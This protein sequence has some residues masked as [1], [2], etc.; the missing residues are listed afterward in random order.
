MY[1]QT[2]VIN[3]GSTQL[4]DMMVMGSNTTASKHEAFL[5]FMNGKNISL[6]FASQIRI[7][8]DGKG[9]SESSSPSVSV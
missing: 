8:S 5:E 7:T 4:S 6:A 1:V 2:K 9:S 3:L